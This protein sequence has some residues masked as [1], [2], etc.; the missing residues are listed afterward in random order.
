MKQTLSLCWILFTDH[1]KSL[2]FQIDHLALRKTDEKTHVAVFWV[3][4]FQIQ[5]FNNGRL[6]VQWQRHFMAIVPFFGT[7]RYNY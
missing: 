3:F 6:G 4:F 5:N 1:G 7:I 2:I